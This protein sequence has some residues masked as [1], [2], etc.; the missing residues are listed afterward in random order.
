MPHVP[1]SHKAHTLLDDKHRQSDRSIDPVPLL[2]RLRLFIPGRP[3]GEQGRRAT[4]QDPCR[5]TKQEIIT[6]SL[7]Q[8]RMRVTWTP[9]QSL[10][11]GVTGWSNMPCPTV[12]KPR[13]F[14]YV[15]FFFLLFLSFSRASQPGFGVRCGKQ[16]LWAWG[17]VERGQQ[18]ESNPLEFVWPSCDKAAAT[19]VDDSLLAWLGAI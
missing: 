16:L 6:I 19:P 9:D 4:Q 15:L 8:S 14:S 18:A 3:C 2:C 7:A 13:P 5:P 12:P 1:S 17:G 10:E 11:K